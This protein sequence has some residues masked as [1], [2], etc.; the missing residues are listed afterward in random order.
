MNQKMDYRLNQWR[1]GFSFFPENPSTDFAEF[2]NVKAEG[3]LVKTRKGRAKYLAIS[4]TG[5]PVNGLYSL[6]T[7]SFYATPLQIL[8]AFKDGTVYKSLLNWVTSGAGVASWTAITGSLGTYDTSTTYPW[9]FAE[10]YDAVGKTVFCTNGN[11]LQQKLYFD[12]SIAIANLKIT[13]MG[14]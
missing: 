1:K 14:S 11:S 13:T 4:T 2:K 5:T 10:Y 6:T 3:N 9:K 12:G 7:P 8:I